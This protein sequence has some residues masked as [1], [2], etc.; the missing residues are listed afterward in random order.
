LYPCDRSR[1]AKT[2]NNELSA[3]FVIQSFRPFK[4]KPLPRRSA[5]AYKANAS[6]PELDSLSA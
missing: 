3:P 6:E 5:R 2:M 1:F 4:T